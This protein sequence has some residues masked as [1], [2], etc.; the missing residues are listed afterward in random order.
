[1]SRRPTAINVSFA[2]PVNVAPIPELENGYLYSAS[3]VGQFQYLRDS[4]CYNPTPA[5][6][7]YC[8][9]DIRRTG[10]SD[11]RIECLPIRSGDAN[12]IDNADG[13]RCEIN[14]TGDDECGEIF[15]NK[16]GR[17]GDGPFG[18][19]FFQCAGNSTNAVEA[20][21]G[22]AGSDEDAG[23]AATPDGSARNFRLARLGVSCPSETGDGQVYV[24]DD[25]YFE[26]SGG[27][28]IP[29]APFPPSDELMCLTGQACGPGEC[30]FETTGVL[31]KA[32]AENF[33][34]RCLA[35]AEPFTPAPTP[36]I[37]PVVTPLLTSV[38]FQATWGVQYDNTLS[39][40]LDLPVT[41][42]TD[43]TTVTITIRCPLSTI[44]L[45]NATNPLSTTCDVSGDDALV[46]IDTDVSLV[47][48]YGSSV[49]YVS[50]CVLVRMCAVCSG[51]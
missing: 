23:C 13:L 28:F 35:T 47:S 26:C 36:T 44:E 32:D 1:M 7:L 20:Y 50:G 25:Y 34:Y 30:V 51:V 16:D 41:E 9:G 6:L 4:F 40:V 49:T 14:C 48:K 27:S 10:L 12:Y 3:Y 37:Q 42:C 22:V 46:C 33:Q 17:Y 19:I 15:L 39:A 8:I 43:Q 5:I 29:F 18:Q 11:L 2:P 24:F 31:V 45:V 21:F 38:L